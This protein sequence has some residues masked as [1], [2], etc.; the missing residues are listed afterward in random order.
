MSL[1]YCDELGAGAPRSKRT[2][3]H[4][5]VSR[6]VMLNRPGGSPRP[7]GAVAGCTLGTPWKMRR[8]GPPKTSRSPRA[9]LEI[10]ERAGAPLD[11]GEAEGAGVAEADR[12]HRR[13]RRLLAVLMQA[14]VGAWS[15]QVDDRRVR[16]VRLRRR[17]A[18]TVGDVDCRARQLGEVA[19][20]PLDLQLA[21]GFR[22]AVLDHLPHMAYG[23]TA[24]YTMV[25]SAAGRPNAVRAAAS[26]CSHNPLPLVLPCHRVVRSDGTIG[27][28]L[29]GTEA[30]ATLLAMEQR[31]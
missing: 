1:I 29:A 14:E 7:S 11:A 4:K 2:T 5:P 12:H 28:Y 15:V 9:Q 25:A 24:S 22:R 27:Q 3:A 16:R 6:T 31:A 8:L 18:G 23:S 26:A 10:D 19:R 17:V 20:Q 13:I 21:H 30:K